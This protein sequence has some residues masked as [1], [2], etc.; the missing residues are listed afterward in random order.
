MDYLIN[1]ATGAD[2][3]RV[4]DLVLERW[5]LDPASVYAGSADDMGPGPGLDVMILRGQAPGSEFDTEFSGSD[6]F[7]AACGR[8]SE[9]ELT[10]LLCHELGARALISDGGR[11]V[12]PRMLVTPDGWHGRVVVDEESLDEGE[13]KILY[14]YQPV[15]AA[16]EIPV[17]DPPEWQVG[18]Y[19]DGKIP[20][21]G[22]L[23][24]D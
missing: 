4:K 8:M 23:D 14:A 18:W 2:P 24:P 1:F 5:S 15:P 10:T 9:L 17:Q 16:P 19:E 11:A 6:D 21:S 20:E 22:Y 3:Q 12:Q 7:A 13:F